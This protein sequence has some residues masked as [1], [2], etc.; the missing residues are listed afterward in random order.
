MRLWL[1]LPCGPLG[2][3]AHAEPLDLKWLTI[4]AN[5]SVAVS[6]APTGA[7]AWASGCRAL[8]NAGESTSTRDPPTSSTA[9]GS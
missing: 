3:P 8:E 7:K 2:S 1:Q 6:P 5:A 9:D 4:T